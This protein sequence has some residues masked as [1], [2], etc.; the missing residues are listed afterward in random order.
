MNQR[1]TLLHGRRASFDK[2]RMRSNFGGTKK[3]PHPELVEGRTASIQAFC[4]SNRNSKRQPV[5]TL[6]EVG[7]IS[8]P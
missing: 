3:I 5:V 1:F 2:L 6:R 4:R 7:Y 8:G